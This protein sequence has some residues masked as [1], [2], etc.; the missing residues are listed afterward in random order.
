MYGNDGRHKVA[1]AWAAGRAYSQ[2]NVSTNG[3]DLFSYG[4]EVGT[5][6]SGVKVARCCHY[7]VTTAKH[8]SAFKG[9]ADV[10]WH[11][12]DHSR[13]ACVCCRGSLG[14]ISQAGAA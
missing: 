12:P 7:S 3:H 6:I 8:C 1:E 14:E 9:A 5:T 13:A 4:H 11:C 2:G 10:V